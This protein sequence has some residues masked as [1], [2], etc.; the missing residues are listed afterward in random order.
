VLF[1]QQTPAAIDAGAFHNDVVAVANQNVLLHHASAYATAL[2]ALEGITGVPAGRVT[3]DQAVDS[4]IFNSQLVTLADGSKSLVAP[5]ECLRFPTVQE[6][7]ESLR[8][9]GIIHS[10]H[11][12]DVRQSMQNGGGPACLRLRVVLTDDQLSRMH[13]GVMFSDALHRA[14]VL[15][16][17]KHYRDSLSVDDLRDPALLDESRRALDELCGVLHLPAIY[18]F[19]RP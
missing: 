11:Y 6:Y 13:G 9:R 8:E 16:V 1:V 7:V 3:L 17:Q 4:Y 5:T 10:V 12:V 2:P 15:W 14:L 19:Q 18:E